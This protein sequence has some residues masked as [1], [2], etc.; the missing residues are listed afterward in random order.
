MG[1]KKKKKKVDTLT[2]KT[3]IVEKIEMITCIVRLELVP[4]CVR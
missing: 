4:S 2:R 3:L 1:K